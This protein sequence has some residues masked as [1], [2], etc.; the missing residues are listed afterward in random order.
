MALFSRGPDFGASETLPR[1]RSTS[2]ADG[3]AANRHGRRRA[4][5]A[6]LTK[7]RSG[8]TAAIQVGRSVTENR[9]MSYAPL[10]PP[11][12]AP[13][14]VN[15][16]PVLTV[17]ATVVAERLGHPPETAWT[18]C[19]FRRGVHSARAGTRPQNT[20]QAQDAAERH[21]Q[22]ATVKP[23]RQTIRSLGRNIPVLAAGDGGHA[24]R[25][26]ASPRRTEA[27]A[28]IAWAFGDRM[29]RSMP[30]TR[31]MAKRSVSSARPAEAVFQSR[32]PRGS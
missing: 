24:R 14:R 29:K 9:F 20:D 10:M 21:A 16:A 15:R 30:S 11:A 3:E 17:W 12:S 19:R 22:A 1:W 7:I 2:E 26:M 32:H 5:S 13:I 6:A 28:Y 31:P 23:R 4:R 25:M 18:L 27:Q 8:S